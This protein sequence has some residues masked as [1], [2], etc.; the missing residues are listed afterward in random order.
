MYSK[1][2]TYV[3]EEIDEVG[4][5]TFLLLVP[6]FLMDVKGKKPV[7]ESIFESENYKISDSDFNDLQKQTKE[8]FEKFDLGLY[9]HTPNK[10]K[11]PKIWENCF[12]LL[13]EKET[14][15]FLSKRENWIWKPG[16][17]GYFIAEKQGNKVEQYFA[18]KSYK[19]KS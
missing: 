16:S 7:S 17:R 5:C 4:E 2:Q 3:L 12:T 19:V 14:S 8:L 15:E 13:T 1:F 18:K 11:N 9:L 6:R 10:M